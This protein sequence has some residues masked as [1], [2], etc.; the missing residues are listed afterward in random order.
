MRDG[1]AV[2]A[3]PTTLVPAV[4]SQ[5]K[6]V[7]EKARA[8]MDRV[9]IAR[10]KGRIRQKEEGAVIDPRIGGVLDEITA[11][12]DK[13]L[14]QWFHHHSGVQHESI[15]CCRRSLLPAMA[16]MRSAVMKSEGIL[17]RSYEDKRGWFYL[18]RLRREWATGI[19]SASEE[20]ATSRK[21]KTWFMA[22]GPHIRPNGA[23]G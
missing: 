23:T 5:R 7:D 4:A 14:P 20:L 1:L 13:K 10:A 21:A 8:F 16:R 6:N 19:S 22:L 11:L 12:L 15:R 17:E 18:I 3:E 2:G 9:R